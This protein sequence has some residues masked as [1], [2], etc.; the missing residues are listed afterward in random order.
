ML[1]YDQDNSEVCKDVFKTKDGIDRLAQYSSSIG[2]Q[3]FIL[4]VSCV[5]LVL[6]FYLTEPLFF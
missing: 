3:V 6:S 1:D 4:I 2:R 5:T